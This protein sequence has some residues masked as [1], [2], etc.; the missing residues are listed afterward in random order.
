MLGFECTGAQTYRYS[1]P[2]PTVLTYLTLRMKVAEGHATA[3]RPSCALGE[4]P[5]GIPPP[6]AV[7]L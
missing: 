4:N 6:R 5:R 2:I 3:E 7:A 1:L